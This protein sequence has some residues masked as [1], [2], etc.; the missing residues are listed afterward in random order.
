VNT[1]TLCA[2][3]VAL[4]ALAGCG[5]D[6][7]PGSN[8]SSLRVLA[9]QADKPFAAPGETVHLEATSYDPAGRDITWAWAE[10]SNPASSSVEGCLGEIVATTLETGTPPLLGMGVG[11]SGVDLTISPS[12]LDELPP[13]A[14]PSALTG[15]VSVACPGRLEM[16]NSDATGDLLPFRCS[17]DSGAELGLHDNI[18][19]V[20]RVFVRSTD[21]NQNPVIDSITFDGEP[22][23]ADDVK[24]VDGCVT[25]DFAFDDC[26]GKGDHRIAA[27]LTPD[28][29]EVGVDE[30]GRDF[31]EELIVQHYATEGIFE[32]EVRIA[33]EPETRWAA[34][35]TAPGQE[36]HL[37]FF[38]RDDRGGVALAARRVRGR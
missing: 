35:Q 38:A 4:L 30:F 26:E 2:S 24:E 31:A 22:W 15:V 10:C 29:F 19:G 34:R 28:S 16:G 21:R 12:A 37:W 20:K 11:L 27:R 25:D 9:V 6:F 32:Y 33:E 13:E 36:Q 1:T 3:L 23:A 8:I 18:V 5:A 14:R 17:D 7:D